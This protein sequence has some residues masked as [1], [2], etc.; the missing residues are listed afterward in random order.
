MK[1]LVFVSLVVSA[2]A[3]AADPVKLSCAVGSKQVSDGEGVFCSR[4]GA[5]GVEKLEGPYVGLH[6][7]GAVESQGQYLNG[8]RTGHWVFF[9]G[10]GIKTHEA[11]FLNDEFHGKRITF[12]PNGQKKSE[13]TWVAGKL[14]GP[15][16]LEP[17]PAVRAAK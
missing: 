11:D 6:K 15:M 16:A 2:S 7:N 17:N 8:G 12:L 1:N 13:E 9:V 4:G 14:Q 10:K 3:M 5:P